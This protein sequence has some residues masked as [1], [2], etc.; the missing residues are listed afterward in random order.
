[1][2][3]TAKIRTVVSSLSLASLPLMRFASKVATQSARSAIS[4]SMAEPNPAT[5]RSLEQPA[6]SLSNG[7]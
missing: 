1:V 7:G 4:H 2:G 3:P 5:K 6:L